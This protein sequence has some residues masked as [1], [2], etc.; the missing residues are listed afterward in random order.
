MNF[1]ADP[2]HTI[3]NLIQ[4]NRSKSLSIYI[5]VVVSLITSMASLPFIYIDISTQSRGIIRS[6]YDNVPIT[7]IVSGRVISVAMK[8]NKVV[9][10]GDTLIVITVENLESEKAHNQEL[11]TTH[12]QNFKE[13]DLILTGIG[14]IPTNPVFRDEYFK[15]LAQKSELESKVRYAKLKYE[16]HKT[17]LDQKVISKSEYETYFFD[18]EYAQNTLHSLIKQQYAIW[19][20][21][22]NEILLQIKNLQGIIDKIE[23]Q[24][25]NDFII[26]PQSG[27]IENY[28]GVQVGSYINAGQLIADISPDNDLIVETSV[29]PDDIGLIKKNQHVKYQIDAF[30]YNQ[31]GLLKGAV[32][33]IDRNATTQNN[34]TFFKVRCSIDTLAIS[35]KSG[36]TTEVTKGMTLTSR[37]MVTRRSLYDLLFD[38]VDD[39]LNP[40]QIT[41]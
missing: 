16:R 2:V 7:S 22:K 31:W 37:F 33:D 35:L 23:V 30:N 21:Q 41:N 27:T 9:N 38:K 17:L 20:N 6:K 24:K 13:L 36:Y 40:T 8:S 14:A 39:W 15:F 25:N 26:S 18:L 5:L 28:I 11:L 32:V 3:E 1:S 34:L 12:K 19:Q 10:K 4:K 29:A